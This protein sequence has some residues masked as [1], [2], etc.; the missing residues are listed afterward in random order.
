MGGIV[1][2]NSYLNLNTGV[3][4]LQK[5]AFFIFAFF[6]V[7]YVYLF[8]SAGVKWIL[9]SFVLPNVLPTVLLVWASFDLFI[10]IYSKNLKGAIYLI[11]VCLVHQC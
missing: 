2:A 5:S 11:L 9:A 7:A 10:F 4:M 8:T 6:P 1:L 3:L